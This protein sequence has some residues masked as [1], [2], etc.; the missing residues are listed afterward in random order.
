MRAQSSLEFLT[1]YSF[2]FM[3]LGITVSIILFLAGAPALTLPSQCASFSG[4]QCNFVEMY[5]NTITGYSLITFSF[6]NSQSVPINLT[7]MQ[8]EV[9]SLT[10]NGYCTPSYLYPGMTST[11]TVEQNSAPS[12]QTQIQGYYTINA[13]FCNSGQ[14]NLS[15]KNCNYEQVQYSGSFATNPSID[16]AVLFS[17]VAS[18]S[19]PTSNILPFSVLSS[20]PPVQPYNYSIL[21]N[22]DWL[23]NITSN[24]IAYA[25]ATNGT[26]QGTSRLGYPLSAYPQVLSS[27]NNNNVNSNAGACVYSTPYNSMLSIAST[28]LYFDTAKTVTF[29]VVTYGAIEVFYRGA[30][31]TNSWSNVFSGSG[32]KQQGATQYGPRSVTFQQGL[33][34]FEIFWENP[35]GKGEQVFSANGLPS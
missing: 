33:Y 26:L 2:L 24:T 14:A 20:N 15:T 32:W 29:N 19:P 17:V 27:L 21:Q 23:A 3:I 7:S 13:L 35:C 4:P 5:S 18:Q 16:K 22:D 25:F 1:T 11:C 12:T 10:S 6:S 28:T 30:P 31:P 9:K 8:T 34:D